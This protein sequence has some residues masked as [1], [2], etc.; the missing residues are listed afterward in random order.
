MSQSVSRTKIV[1]TI[2][3]ASNGQST[4]ERMIEAGMNVARLNFAHGEFAS[5]AATIATIR[6]AAEAGPRAD[7]DDRGP[8]GPWRH[9]PTGDHRCLI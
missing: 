6:A 1:A 5:H 2:G 8:G 4:L 9:Q 3:P 7:P